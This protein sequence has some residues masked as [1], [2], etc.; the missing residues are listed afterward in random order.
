MLRVA[1]CIIR[2]AIPQ[3]TEWQCV[4]NQIDAAFI[5]AR[6]DFVKRADRLPVSAWLYRPNWVQKC[7]LQAEAGC[8][9]V[10]N[11]PLPPL[12][13]ENAGFRE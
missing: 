2:L 5:L 6:S 8:R 3:P 7:V 4:G 9:S 10:E 12:S 1:D 11:Q 13:C